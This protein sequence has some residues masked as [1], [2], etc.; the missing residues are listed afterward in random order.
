[1][2]GL[3]KAKWGLS[4]GIGLLIAH[5]LAVPG[6]AADPAPAKPAS[7]LPPGYG[8]VQVTVMGVT[9]PF[10]VFGIVKRL[11]QVPGVDHVSFNLLHGLA[12]VRVKPGAVITDDDLR[13]AVRNASYTAGPITWLARPAPASAT[14]A[15]KP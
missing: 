3:S 12:D 9:A 11:G 2:R 7:D 15:T 13:R 8:E 1:M 10:T 6:W 4:L 14:A 5:A